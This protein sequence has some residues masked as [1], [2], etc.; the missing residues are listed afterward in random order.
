M[1]RLLLLIMS[2][3]SQIILWAQNQRGRLMPEDYMDFPDNTAN[4]SDDTFI[5]YLSLVLLIIMGIVIIWFKSALKSSRE[6]EIRDKT[7]FLTNADV[8]AFESVYRATQDSI[9][10][11]KPKQFLVNQNGVVKFPKY[12]RCIILEYYSENRSYVK[13]KFENYNTPLYVGRW[14]LRTPDQIN[15]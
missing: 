13:V 11:L 8:Y 6:K 4:S 14:Y 1:K 15:D 5:G 7:I 9:T 3:C 2:L 10:S 12:S